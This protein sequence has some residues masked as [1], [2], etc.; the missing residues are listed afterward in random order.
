MSF[1]VNSVVFPAIDSSFG[2]TSLKRPEP[3]VYTISMT[4]EELCDLFDRI[5]AKL[6]N[7]AEESEETNLSESSL[8][9][10]TAGS[11]GSD[12]GL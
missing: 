6:S 8:S 4:V 12:R 10:L 9:G 2:G 11:F 1:G 3:V 7:E 5:T